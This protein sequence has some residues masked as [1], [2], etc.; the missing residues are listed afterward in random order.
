MAHRRT[1]F[2]QTPVMS[3]PVTHRSVERALEQRYQAYTDEVWRLI[4]AGVAVMQRTQTTDPRVSEIVQEAGLSNQ[5]FYRHFKSKDELLLAILDDGQRRLVEILRR[6]MAE[7]SSGMAKVTRWTEVILSQ[8]TNSSVAQ[9]TRC[10]VLNGNRLRALFPAE[11]RHY[12]DL[13]AAPLRE[14]LVIA[15]AQGEIPT[16][17]DPHR[18]ARAMFRMVSGTMS[19]FVVDRVVPDRQDIEHLIG[20]VASALGHQ[21]ESPSD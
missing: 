4:K 12:E 5:A 21:E 14:A 19:I 6:N 15:G 13:I 8:A 7:E 10:F 20:L 17:P 18:D 9:A 3:R 11:S 1:D 16:R 2:D